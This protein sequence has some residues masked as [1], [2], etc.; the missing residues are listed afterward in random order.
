MELTKIQKYL[1]DGLRIYGVH[2]DQVVGMIV[3]LKDNEPGMLELIDYMREQDPTAHEI[4][5]KSTE[6]IRRE[7]SP[8]DYSNIPV[9]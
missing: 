1:I 3:F 8:M 7:R 6:I 5:L 4:I 9:E 2:R